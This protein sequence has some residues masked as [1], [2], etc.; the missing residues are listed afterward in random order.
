MRQGMHNKVKVNFIYQDTVMRCKMQ[1][2]YLSNKNHG[3]EMKI[4]LSHIPSIAFSKPLLNKNNEL[5]PFP[6]L[7]CKKRF[8]GRWE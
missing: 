7:S 5:Q 6:I 3:R 2:N 1:V 8:V 4:K